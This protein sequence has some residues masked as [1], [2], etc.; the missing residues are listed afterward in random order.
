[1]GADQ[2]APHHHRS[3]LKQKNK[4]FKGSTRSQSRG[5]T[6]GRRTTGK[7]NPGMPLSRQDR[8]NRAT[9]VRQT[10][11]AA[12]TRERRL[13]KGRDGMSR[14]VVVVPL[15]ASVELAR[16]VPF[17]PVESMTG[18]TRWP[19]Y[20]EGNKQNL[21]LFLCGRDGPSQADWLMRVLDAAQ[22]AD[23]VLLVAHN[24]DAD[25]DM[26][27][28]DAL[29]VIRAIGLSSV[30]AIVQGAAAATDKDRWLRI[31]QA[32][33][34]AINKI[35]SFSTEGPQPEERMVAEF[36][37]LLCEQHLAGLSW[38]DPR[39]FLVAESW[40]AS[41]D[42][43]HLRITGFGRG[44][45]PFSA[46][47]L[48][49]VP[50]L[51]EN[52]V[53]SRIEM[54]PQGMLAHERSADRAE[55]LLAEG[56][57]TT[58]EVDSKETMM[59]DT[60]ADHNLKVEGDVEMGMETE[61]H[62]AG[63]LVPKG[64]SSYQ[65]AWLSE[66]SKVPF[67]E[68]DEE[69]DCIGQET[70]ESDSDHASMLDVEE[71]DAQLANHKQRLEFSERHFA[72]EIELDPHTSARI[73]LQK[74]RGVASLRTSTWEANQ[75]LPVEYGRIF[76]FANFRQSR[77][78]VLEEAP[79]ADNPI[80]TGQRIC[81][82]VDISSSGRVEDVLSIISQLN[83][84]LAVYGLLKHEQRQ[85]VVNFSFGRTKSFAG[86]LENKEELLAVM[87][88]R[89]FLINPIL[90]EHGSTNLHKM[91]RHVDAVTMQNGLV[92]GT[93]YAPVIFNPAPV[94]LF[95]PREGAAEEIEL[96]GVGCVLDLDPQ[97]IILKRITLTGSPYKIHK[98]SVVM[99][100]MFG[101]A[102]DIAWFRPVELSTRLGARGHIRESLGTH[103][104]MKCLF[105]RQI[106]H[107]DTI[108]M[109]LYKRVF[110]KWS[111]RPVASSR[112]GQC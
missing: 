50:A 42:G 87:G 21:D 69:Y 111:T 106:F 79:E 14:I 3:S 57:H 52:F 107:H 24:A 56:E 96:V 4:P 45:R 9:M 74:Y 86:V 58:D 68:D 48:V 51:G 78:A 72:D 67:D 93:V 5:R 82:H 1:M 92:V 31:L 28:Q 33:C 109:H 101:N 11:R 73:R 100:F 91:L 97:R 6:E 18:R 84:P 61:C 39:P 94:L 63:K 60:E 103:G 29:A 105:D 108:A 71:H 99:R 15:S 90:S 25:L 19:Y 65:A 32:E 17:G 62:S 83:R 16:V 38:R 41:E 26:P 34:S 104:Y 112:A 54:V 10:K 7:A 110:P 43:N 102:A 66:D 23:C 59:L 30:T 12:V 55:M 47:R 53:L 64:T 2:K 95:R 88:F 37:R 70:G 89:K 8:K 13:Y 49:H 22:V 77:K 46:N 40:E 76:R 35:Y 75:E 81:L 36:E 27:G 98:R 85:T 80:N 20:S 44:G